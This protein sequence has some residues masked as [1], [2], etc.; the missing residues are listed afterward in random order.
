M[1][2]STH[3]LLICALITVILSGSVSS[4]QGASPDDWTM[5]RHDTSHSGTT[6]SATQVA[7]PKLLWNFKTGAAV[8]SSAA[9]AEGLVFFG[10]RDYNIYCLDA[11][12][13]QL[14]W[15]FSTAAAVD[16]SPAIAG[17]RVFVGSDDGWFYCIDISS[18]MPVWISLIGGKTI[19]SPAVVK[20]LVFVG[21]GKQ[22]FYCFN[23]TNGDLVWKFP[24]SFRVDSSPA[25]KDGAVYFSADDFHVYA[26]NATTGEQIWKQHT[27]SVISSPSVDGGSIFVGST[28]GYVVA[29]N[30]SNGKKI[31]QYK[32]QDVVDS[33]PAVFSQRVFVGADDNN[34]YCLNSSNGKKIWHAQ[35]GYWVRSS[36]VV[37]GGSVYVGSQD[38]HIYCFN[39]TDGSK[40]WSTK[41]GNYIDSSPAVVN[42]VLYVGSNDGSLYAYALDQQTPESTSSQKSFFWTTIVFDALTSILLASII[43][44]AVQYA[45]ANKP[46]TLPAQKNLQ[47]RNWFTRHIDLVVVLILLSISTMYFVDLSN[48]PLWI[49]DEQTYSQWTYNMVNTGDYFTPHAF[50][51]LAVWIGKPPLFM[52]LMSLAFQVFGANSFAA[53]LPSAI[54]AAL[55]LVLIFYLGK[56]LYN[57]TVGFLSALVLGT[58]STFYLFAKHAMM[59][60]TFTFFIVAS[61][62][63]FVQSQKTEKPTKF[64]LLS[65]IFFGLA[66]LTKQVE[67]LLL[68][69]I[70]MI[71]LLAT[72]R[73]IKVFFTKNFAIFWGVG[74]LMVTPWLA[75]MLVSFKD[76]FWNWFVLYCGI[77]RT[78]SPIEGHSGNFLFYFSFLASNETLWAVLLPFAGALSL[79]NAAAKRVE[80][81]TLLLAW[82]GVVLLVFTVAQTKLAWYILPAFPA[83]ALATGNLLYQLALRLWHWT[84]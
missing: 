4:A 35:T 80:Q 77:Q 11:S 25:F 79:F 54:F 20:D 38:N 51:G 21:S 28:D 29:L 62:Y 6:L 73:S 71:Y 65:G 84:H 22:G 41:T 83:F 46:R 26:L 13:G 12:N 37:L 61:V 14:V 45:L 69:L 9:V 72:N 33:S 36:P 50:G 59:D 39:T 3:L 48:G 15:N 16:S 63:F 70:I 44:Y 67:A 24:I 23:A 64:V 56:L 82:M 76:D 32:L 78:L 34:L 52:W 49:A 2:T 31:W 57:R 1:R 43:F 58:F 19:S 10:S 68:P 8:V 17:G 30:A 27:G 60:V 47:K 42:G 66:L 40:I 7:F 5:F 55:S 18:G 74:L 53:R 75:F 81:D